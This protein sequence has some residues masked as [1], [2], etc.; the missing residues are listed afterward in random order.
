MCRCNTI[1]LKV[2]VYLIVHCFFIRFFCNFLNHFFH[3]SVTLIET[4]LNSS[5]TNDAAI[6]LHSFEEVE[7]I[8][9]QRTFKRFL[10]IDAIYQLTGLYKR[11]R[12]IRA[13]IED[14]IDQIL[15]ERRRKG[16]GDRLTDDSN[17]H[18][19]LDQLLHL[20]K[21]GKALTPT[22]IRQNVIA[23]I[24]AVSTFLPIHKDM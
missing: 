15:E 24:F 7:D 23:I 12:E 11:E 16:V 21:D 19:F 22:E 8:I 10:H 3:F 5:L 13:A 9:S 4:T 6:D 18:I 2:T 17:S 20:T 14:M 1:S